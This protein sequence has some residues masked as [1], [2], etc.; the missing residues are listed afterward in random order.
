MSTASLPV[1]FRYEPAFLSEAEERSLV[2]SIQA[3]EFAEVRMR[4]VV[5][6]RRV[7]HFGW[8]YGYDR[9]RIEPGEPIP[10]FLLPL[11]ARLAE[12]AAVA[13]DELGE[14]LITEYSPGAG[15][16][17]HRDAPAFGIVAAVSLLAPVRMRFRRGEAGNR[18]TAEIVLEPRSAYLI[19]GGS[20]SKWQ[21]GIPPAK[22]LRY[23]ITYRTLRRARRAE[24]A[25]DQPVE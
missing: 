2:A 24:P 10:E 17:W 11:R 16:G 1:G 9:A 12:L 4:G 3:M 6:R 25:V 8:H 14:A 19:T 21:H 23:S 5:A 22:A 15:I 7:R 20:R 13:P 18:E